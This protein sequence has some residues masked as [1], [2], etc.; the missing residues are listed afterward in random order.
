MGG[1]STT[2][3]AQMYA[4]LAD[5]EA[6]AAA[7]AEL[8][9]RALPVV[10]VD[11]VLGAA[12]LA[13]ASLEPAS[14]AGIDNPI[15]YVRRVVTTKAIDLLR[16][17]IRTQTHERELHPWDEDDDDAGLDLPAPGAASVADDVVAGETEDA[18]RVALHRLLARRRPW[19]A[20]AG[21][22]ALT[23]AVHRDVALPRAVP[24]PEGAAPGQADRWAALWLAGERHCFATQSRAEDAAMRQRRSRALRAIDEILLEA[25]HA[26]GLEPADG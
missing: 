25:A 7:A 13:V 22:T 14:L 10:L 4:W 19:I 12:A 15:G 20:A 21:M 9:R 26:I 3:L 1:A 24:S 11:D 5:D 17:R 16:G 23:L 6:R 2:P 8:H 18:L